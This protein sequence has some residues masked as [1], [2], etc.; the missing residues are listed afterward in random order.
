ME[1]SHLEKHNGAEEKDTLHCSDKPCYTNITNCIQEKRFAG[2][3]EVLRTPRL[4]YTMK[5]QRGS[6][7]Q[8]HTAD[9]SV[10]VVQCVMDIDAVIDALLNIIPKRMGSLRTDLDGLRTSSTLKEI[11]ALIDKNAEELN[12]NLGE[13]YKELFNFYGLNVSHIAENA[14][15]EVWNIYLEENDLENEELNRK[16]IALADKSSMLDELNEIFSTKTGGELLSSIAKN[17]MGNEAL[18][19]NINI[20]FEGPLLDAKIWSEGHKLK[21]NVQRGF[22]AGSGNGSNISIPSEQLFGIKERKNE[23]FIDRIKRVLGWQQKD[24]PRITLAHELIHA[25]HGQMGIMPPKGVIAEMQPWPFSLTLD[26][27]IDEM[28]DAE[29]IKKKRGFEATFPLL[30]GGTDDDVLTTGIYEGIRDIRYPGP[31][32]EVRHIN[33]NQIRKELGLKRRTKY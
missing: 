18:G 2:S 32:E 29:H 23:T 21:G 8:H 28:D 12:G 20:G 30:A 16:E 4:T 17:S 14:T 26:K 19:V 5:E 22:E 7:V 31:M 24:D 27:M 25:L 11:K 1:F 33:E 9:G 13:I 15:D 10:A 3:Q 6:A